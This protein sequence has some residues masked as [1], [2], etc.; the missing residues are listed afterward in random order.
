MA[1]HCLIVVH[2]PSPSRWLVGWKNESLLMTSTHPS[3]STPFNPNTTHFLFSF[4][5]FHSSI[6]NVIPHF[7]K[8]NF[9]S[10]FILD[11]DS[12]FFFKRVAEGLENQQHQ[13]DKWEDWIGH[14]FGLHSKCC[15]H[16]DFVFHFNQSIQNPFSK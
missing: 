11:L 7:F 10:F 4:F 16:S 8:N 15:F 13:N 2:H 9:K 5:Q 12:F 6:S 3:S 14:Q 1:N